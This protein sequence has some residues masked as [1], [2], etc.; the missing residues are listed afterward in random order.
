MLDAMLAAIRPPHGLY[1]S[2]HLVRP[3]ERIR[4]AGATSR[5]PDFQSVRS[6]SFA[7]ACERGCRGTPRGPSVVFRGDDG[8]RALSAFRTRRG[9]PPCSRLG[10][11]GAS[12]RRTQTEPLVS[13]I[14]T[15]S[16]DHIET[17][18][19]TLEAI[20]VRRRASFVLG[21]ARSGVVQPE[22]TPSSAQCDAGATIRSTRAGRT[23]PTGVR[24]SL[25][26]NAP[27]GQRSRRPLRPCESVFSARARAGGRSS[28][29]AAGPR[30]ARWPG[31][32]QT[33]SRRSFDSLGRRATTSP[34]PKR[35]PR[36][37]RY[38]ADRS[39]SSVC[40][41][42]DKDHLPGI[43]GSSS[44]TSPPSWRPSPRSPARRARLP[45]SPPQ[46]ARSDFPRSRA[47][48]GRRPGARLADGRPG[49]LVPSPGRSTWSAP[50]TRCSRAGG[51]SAPCRCRLGRGGLSSVMLATAC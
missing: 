38:A 1:T 20:A 24:L 37:W 47:G 14:V 36:I 9:E 39:R 13:A 18:G 8:S 43:L 42:A 19:T 31:R 3:N 34:A 25:D 41:M 4:I 27:A 40:A 10:L 6:G 12:T 2:P 35:W 5:T 17:L 48:P 26:G 44:R 46:R 28:G 22:V 32:L 23:L 33:D 45:S 11:G 50:S 29:D 21:A 51:A 30:I 16:L 15:V 7:M 49:G